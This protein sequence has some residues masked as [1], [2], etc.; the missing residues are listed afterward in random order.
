MRFRLPTTSDMQIWSPRRCS[1][2]IIQLLRSNRADFPLHCLSL[3]DRCIRT[4][5]L[6]QLAV[7]TSNT[8]CIRSTPYSVCYFPLWRQAAWIIDRYLDR[9]AAMIS[10]FQL[11]GNHDKNRSQVAC[12]VLFLAPFSILYSTS[13]RCI[14][15]ITVCDNNKFTIHVNF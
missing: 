14:K 5:I 12:T 15:C 9:A 10:G 6:V 2:G 1:L 4:Y 3:E 7:R 8:G 13:L 11:M